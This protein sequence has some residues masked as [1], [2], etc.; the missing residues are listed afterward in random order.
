MRENGGLD[1][2]ENNTEGEIELNMSDLDNRTLWKLDAYLKE[3][4]VQPTTEAG[5]VVNKVC[6]HG[7][8]VIVALHSGVFV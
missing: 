7:L 8:S 2:K 3:H 6:L 1:K 5:V 4:N